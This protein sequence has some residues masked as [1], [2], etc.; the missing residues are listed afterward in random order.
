MTYILYPESGAKLKAGPVTVNDVAYND[1][2]ASLETVLVSFDSWQP[3][4]F[5][6]PD[7]PY[8]WCR[9]KAQTSLKPGTPE[10]WARAADALG[11]S[12]PLDGS[13]FWNP[14]GYEWTDMFK[15]EVT[16]T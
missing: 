2:S 13:I 14:N 12:Q 8:A 6:V 3:G 16:V 7:S 1:G 11:H 9:W 15:C 10:I 4:K 5:E